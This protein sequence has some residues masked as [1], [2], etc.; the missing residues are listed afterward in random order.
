MIE[1]GKSRRSTMFMIAGL[2]ILFVGCITF[3]YLWLD[4][5]ISIS[6]LDSSNRTTEQAYLRISALLEREWANLS[7]QEVL[8]RLEAEAKRYPRDEILVKRDTSENVIWFNNTRFEFKSG[9]LAKI[10]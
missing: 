1:T 9:R 2:V 8:A 10:R 6:Y 5:S 7:E 3:A 4:R